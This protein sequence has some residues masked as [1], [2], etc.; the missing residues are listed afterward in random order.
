MRMPSHWQY[1]PER[2][3]AHGYSE[4]LYI[5]FITVVEPTISN[6]SRLGDL[7]IGIYLGQLV[8]DKATVATI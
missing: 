2:H 5:G 3:A 6:Q 8:Q 7:K 1:E 4:H